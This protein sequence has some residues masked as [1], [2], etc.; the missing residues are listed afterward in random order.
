[1][2]RS[3]SL[4]V[5]PLVVSAFQSPASQA[6]SCQSPLSAIKESTFGMGCFWEPSEEL[7]KVDGVVDTIAGYT[8]N[9][10]ATEA[11][12]YDTVCFGRQ[13]VEG[14]RVKYDDEKISYE[15]LLETFFQTQKPK[16][17]SR[18]Y[19]SI[20]FPHDK[21]QEKIASAWKSKNA[22][23]QR[24]DGFLPEWTEIEPQSKFYQAEGYHQRYWQKQRPRFA[25]IFGLLAIATGALNNFVPDVY[26]QSMVNFANASVLAI[27]L[28][29]ILERV[30]DAK[31]VEL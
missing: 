9:P 16:L 28:V 15:Q 30:L 4:F 5:L 25:L 8:G 2:N 19:A 26:H 13:W 23:I 27:G 31:V 24:E 3:L 10:S 6:Y 11:P 18:Q 29:Q 14:V 7:L 21:E 20:I 17:G 22:N 1:M 12:T